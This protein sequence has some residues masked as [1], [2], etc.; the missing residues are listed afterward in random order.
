MRLPEP[1]MK[2]CMEQRLNAIGQLAILGERAVAN[3]PDDVAMKL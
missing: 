1:T 2:Q 3:C